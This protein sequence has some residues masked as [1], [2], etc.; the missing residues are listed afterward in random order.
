VNAWLRRVWGEGKLG[1]AIETRTAAAT[2]EP[3]LGNK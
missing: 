2:T 1:A 3:V